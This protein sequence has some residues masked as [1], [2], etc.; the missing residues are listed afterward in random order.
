MLFCGGSS[1]DNPARIEWF[2]VWIVCV[3]N[4]DDLLLTAQRASD[5]L[6][7]CDYSSRVRTILKLTSDRRSLDP[8]LRAATIY[9][10]GFLIAFTQRRDFFFRAVSFARRFF[11]A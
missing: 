4:I 10:E 9:I 11:G 2:S 6:M 8:R 3:E 7:I 5:H 1:Q